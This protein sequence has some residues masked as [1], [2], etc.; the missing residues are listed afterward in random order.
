MQKIQI[1]YCF[2]LVNKQV[3][4]VIS[5]FDISSTVDENLQKKNN[6]ILSR[7]IICENLSPALCWTDLREGLTLKYARLQVALNKTKYMQ[8]E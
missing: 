7:K 6:K 4:D 8:F 1:I 5:A 3:Q 2:N